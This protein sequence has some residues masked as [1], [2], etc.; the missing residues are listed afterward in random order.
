M[1][2]IDDSNVRK[3]RL[4]KIFD[5]AL[6]I[7]Y[8][9]IN[10][11][12]PLTPLCKI[13]EESCCR[14]GNMFPYVCRWR[15]GLTYTV[16]Y[17]SLVGEGWRFTTACSLLNLFKITKVKGGQLYIALIFYWNLFLYSYKFRRTSDPFVQNLSV[18][19]HALY[20]S[21]GG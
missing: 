12:E 4:L 11:G 20:F 18:V 3:T 10:L 5:W 14:D 21:D 8:T 1:K 9:T 2:K 19:G 16:F 6:L 15:H 13:L 17:R 7:L